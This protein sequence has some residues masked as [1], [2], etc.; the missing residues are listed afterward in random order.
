MMVI[1]NCSII[2][3]KD[4]RKNDAGIIAGRIY[5]CIEG[6]D[7][8]SG[9]VT[10]STN[11]AE[12]ISI[13]KYRIDSTFDRITI[14]TDSNG[15]FFRKNLKPGLYT[16]IVRGQPFDTYDSDSFIK[17]VMLGRMSCGRVRITDIR[18]GRDSISYLYVK[19]PVGPEGWDTY[20]HYYQES[21]KWDGKIE[22][23]R[24][25]ITD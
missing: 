4:T 10:L 24:N 16:A 7:F 6:F 14:K 25:Q 3:N 20:E 23:I 18:I 5:S 2:S 1:L 9:S 22:K 11:D 21:H 8:I 19:L 12:S 13:T 15:T 17:A